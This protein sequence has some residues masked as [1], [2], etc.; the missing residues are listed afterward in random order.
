[1]S[2]TVLLSP[3][4]AEHLDDLLAQ[5]ADLLDA[6][7]AADS[8]PAVARLVPDAYPGDAASSR[9]FRGV[10]ERDLLARRAADAQRVRADLREG[11]ALADAGAPVA[12]ALALDADAVAAW[13]RTL[14]ALRLVLASRMGITAEEDHVPDD[15]R[16]AVYEWLGYR[17]DALVR[18][19]DAT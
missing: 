19:A 4:E 8:D 6:S 1:M 5:F 16:S 11:G 15:P 2:V 14:A 10:T 3:G 9:E 7:G 13:L 17:L 12:L 18:A